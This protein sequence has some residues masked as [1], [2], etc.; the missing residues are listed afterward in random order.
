MG[1]VPATIAVDAILG[2]FDVL[3]ILD[4]GA[5]PRGSPLGEAAE[6]DGRGGIDRRVRSPGIAVPP[7][8]R[9]GTLGQ[10]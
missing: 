5:P 3:E 6:E 8:A 7:T 9:A 2:G 4:V 1:I 10:A